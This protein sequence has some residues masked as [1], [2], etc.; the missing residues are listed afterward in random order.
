MPQADETGTDTVRLGLIGD[1]IARSQAPRLHELA[2]RLT[3]LRVRYDRLTPRVLDMDVEAVFADA[4]AAGY[5]G[6]NITYPYKERVVPLPTSSGPPPTSVVV[7][8][9][10][11]CSDCSGEPMWA[12][13]SMAPA[14]TM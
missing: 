5:R 13:L 9:A 10:S 8:P 14:V 11:A 6:L 12:W 1:N 3:G 7:P 4:R 2:G